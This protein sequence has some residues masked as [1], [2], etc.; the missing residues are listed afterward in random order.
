MRAVRQAQPA[1]QV[2]KAAYDK[3]SNA[4]NVVYEPAMKQPSLVREARR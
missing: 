3:Q 4:L 1:N 2:E